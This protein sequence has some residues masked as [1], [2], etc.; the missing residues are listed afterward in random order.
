SS[1]LTASTSI[2]TLNPQ[3]TAILT[4]S[5]NAAAYHLLPGTYSASVVFSNQTSHAT[6]MRQFVLLAGENLVQNGGFESYPYSLPYWVQTGGTTKLNGSRYPTYNWDFV[7]A[8]AAYG[9]YTG[10][11]PH[12][13]TNFC[14]LGEP[15]IIGY[16]SQ[17]IPTVPGQHYL[18]STWLLNPDSG[19]TQEFFVNWN[20]NS[21]TTNTIYSLL[22]PPAF[23]SWSNIVLFVTATSTNTTLQFGG[24]ND[25]GLWGLDDVSLVP[26]PWPNIMLS[27]IGGNAVFTWDSLGGLTYRLQYSTNLLSPNWSNLTTNIAAGPTLSVTNAIGP[28]PEVFYRALYTP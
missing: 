26:I 23:T 9:G 22:N 11:N 25:P 5:L 27:K 24:R 10:Y 28:R 7:D 16:I 15:D 20:T 14:V 2:G 4:V 3:T 12:S 13:G 6:R 8:G 17:I 19:T 21:A 1:W 18:F